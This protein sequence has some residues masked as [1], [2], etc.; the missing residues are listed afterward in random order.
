MFGHDHVTYQRES[1]AV[2]RLTEN[3]NKGV[4]SANGAQ[5]RQ[6]P[7]A[8]EGDEMQMAAPVVA[9]EFVGHESSDKSKAR[10]SKNERVGHPE[11]QSPEKQNQFLSK[12]VQ[13]WY[14]ST[15]RPC[16]QKRAKGW[17]TRPKRQSPEKQNQF[18]SKDVQ[19]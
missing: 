5:K 10:P 8:S 16:Q 9:N 19:E 15:V 1:V 18:L 13:E 12:D 6:P 2:A 7:K 4:S 17:A 3:L 14:Y 11:R